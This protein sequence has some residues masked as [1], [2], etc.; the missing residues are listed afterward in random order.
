[1][2]E[3]VLDP[4]VA[5]SVFAHAR[6]AGPNECCGILLGRGHHVAALHRAA[7][8][9]VSP[10]A[11]LIDPA[12]HIAARRLARQAGL[13]VVGFYHSHPASAP[14]PSPRDIAEASY[15]EAIHLIA[16][17]ERQ[18]EVLRAFTIRGGSVEELAIRSIDWS[19]V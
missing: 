17:I 19:G 2:E 5:Q 13:D 7:N 9:H 14:V 11:F 8:L 16:G 6:D 15:E 18:R 3:V 10:T 12:D 1:M 4:G